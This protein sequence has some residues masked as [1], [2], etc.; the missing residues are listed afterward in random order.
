MLFADL[1]KRQAIH[2]QKHK[3]ITKPKF[4][5]KMK[6]YKIAS[7]DFYRTL[8]CDSVELILSKSMK[9]KEK[10]FFLHL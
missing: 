7:T 4:D 6:M 9:I 8:E 1:L 5:W 2:H 3:K 10:K